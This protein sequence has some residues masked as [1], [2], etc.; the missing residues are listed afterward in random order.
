MALSVGQ[1]APDFTLTSH[2]DAKVKLSDHLG[3][4]VLVAVRLGQVV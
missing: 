3:K 2:T 1:R 4:N